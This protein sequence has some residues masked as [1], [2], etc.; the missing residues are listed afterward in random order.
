VARKLNLKAQ[1]AFLDQLHGTDIE[2]R[3]SFLKKRSKKLLFLQ[4]MT[5]AAASV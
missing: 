4:K 1:N 3:A 2:G 5:T